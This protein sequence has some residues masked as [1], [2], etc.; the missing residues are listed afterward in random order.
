[1]AASKALIPGVPFV[2]WGDTLE[3]A[4]AAP[5]VNPSYWACEQMVERFWSGEPDPS[6][7]GKSH[8]ALIPGGDSWQ[9]G[10]ASSIE[11]LKEPIRDGCPVM[12]WTG[13]TPVGHSWGLPGLPVSGAFPASR[14]GPRSDLLGAIAPY[15]MFTKVM[16]ELLQESVTMAMRVV[17]GY[18]DEREVLIMHDPSFGP[19]LEVAYEQFDRMWEPLSRAYI[20]AR[21]PDAA[22]RNA[23][24]QATAPYRART[25]NEQAALLYV[26]GYACSCAGDPN[27]GRTILREGLDMSGLDPGYRH[28][29]LVELAVQAM[30]RDDNAGAVELL[31]EATQLVPQH[32]LPWRML[33][34]I[35]AASPHLSGTWN[36]LVARWRFWNAGRKWSQMIARQVLPADFLIYPGGANYFGFDPSAPA[37]PV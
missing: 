7:P 37:A 22:E 9:G 2:S 11:S 27:T 13:L 3:R 8:S 18:D 19:A 12:V 6:A 10:V 15:E 35:Y 33:L 34:G 28:L 26:S 24:R 20:V 25:K 36:V 21:P 23:S 31:R 5:D 16:P 14:L 17:I 1:M 29:F 30:V 32:A 4:E